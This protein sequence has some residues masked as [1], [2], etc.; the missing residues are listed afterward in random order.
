MVCIGSPLP[1]LGVPQSFQCLPF[2]MAS[3]EFQNSGVMPEYVQ[4]FNR[5]PRLPFLIS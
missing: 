4:F 1:Q 2:A 3:H 5:R